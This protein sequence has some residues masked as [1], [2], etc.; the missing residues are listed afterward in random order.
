MNVVVYESLRFIFSFSFCLSL[1]FALVF[2]KSYLVGEKN[3]WSVVDEMFGY[4][5]SDGKSGFSILLISDLFF[6]SH[7]PTY[8]NNNVMNG[9]HLWM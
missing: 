2:E 3:G 7:K 9:I 4:Q 6:G 8:F 5:E 1:F